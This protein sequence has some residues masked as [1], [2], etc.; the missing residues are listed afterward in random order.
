MTPPAHGGVIASGALGEP[1]APGPAASDTV[2]LVVT[3]IRKVPLMRRLLPLLCALALVMAACGDDDTG[4]FTPTT[5]TAATAD[6][7][8]PTT[9]GTETTTS[10]PQG[11]ATSSTTHA[12]QTTTKAPAATTTTTIVPVTTHPGFPS[13]LSRSVIPIDQ[14]NEGWVAVVYSADTISPS[15]DGPSAVYLVSPNGNRYELAVF[16]VGEPEPFDVGNISNDGTHVVI[17]MSDPSFMARV[18][19][20]DIATGAQ[21]DVVTV[22]SGSAISTTL[23]TGRD[24]VVQHTTF[25]P[26]MENLDVYRVNGSLFAEITSLPS[27]FPGVTWLYGLDGT[28]LLLGDTT[29]LLVYSNEG[30]YVRSLDTPPGYCD[31]IRWWDESTILAGC[32]P[33]DVLN[34]SGFYHVLWL[35]PLDGS[36]GSPLTAA[37][38]VNWSV[39]EFG[40]ADAWRVDGEI[41]LQWWGDCAARGLQ[42]RQP[43]GTGDWI[44]VEPTGAHWIHAQAGNNLVVHSIEGCGDFYGP[45]SLIRSDGSLVRTLVPQ[46]AGYQ[47]VISTSGM[48]PVP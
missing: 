30:T 28:Y 21:R 16:N 26:T 42:I 6:S 3:S 18:V 1:F 24:V 25:N 32:I 20:I 22:E 33:Q 4:I 43:G 48:I 31:P 13:A 44:P 45:V 12:Q 29:G 9:T 38:P 7:A 36:P 37:P 40:H 47:G 8:P 2:R 41:V 5:V 14:I 23:P 27:Q 17:Q 39:V 46:I 10:A 35:I 11:Q 15:V 34:N 19:S